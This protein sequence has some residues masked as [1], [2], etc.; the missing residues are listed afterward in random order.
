MISKTHWPLNDLS[1][2]QEISCF[3]SQ[4]REIPNPLGIF[5]HLENFY[6]LRRRGLRTRERTR[7]TKTQIYPDPNR[8][9]I[10]AQWGKKPADG[11]RIGVEGRF[12]CGEMPMKSD[13]LL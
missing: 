11:S 5:Y 10:G 3:L 4:L 12:N 1:Q 8:N 9:K 13:L 2:P 6:F 7:T